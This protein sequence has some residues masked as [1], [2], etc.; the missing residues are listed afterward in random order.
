MGRE[1][2]T[3]VDGL[4]NHL[5][6]LQYREK[7]NMN[8]RLFR[9]SYRL[10]AVGLLGLSLTVLVLSLISGAAR[11]AVR[12]SPARADIVVTTTIQAAIDA[13]E[14]GDTVIIPSGIYTESLT[15]SKAVS[16]TGVSSTTTII[17]AVAGQRVLSITS[18]AID[19]SVVISG[20]KLAGGNA[21]GAYPGDRGGGVYISNGAR[22]L[23]KNTVI[24]NNHAA[25][26]GGGAFVAVGSGLTLVNVDMLSNT[27][28]Y[29]GGGIWNGGTLTVSGSTFISNSLLSLFGAE[30][31]GIFSYKTLTITNSVISGNRATFGGGIFSEDTL[32]VVNSTLAGNSASS[33]GGG[34]YSEGGATVISNTILVSNTGGSGAGIYISEGTVQVNNSE[35]FAN[36]GEIGGGIYNYRGTLTVDHT[37][38]RDNTAEGHMGNSS[39]GGGI[40]TLSD[41]QVVIVDSTFEGNSAE[42][43]GGSIYNHGIATAT[44]LICF[45]NTAFYGAC[46]YNGDSLEIED[47]TIYSNTATSA[48][49]GIYNRSSMTISSSTLSGNIISG[50]CSGAQIDNYET[51]V[52][53]ISSCTISNS[54]EAGVYNSGSVL[55]SDSTISKSR[56]GGI[57][58]NGTAIINNSILSDNNTTTYGGGID[59]LGSLVITGSILTGNSAGLSGGGI[60][61]W[62]ALTMTNSILSGNDARYGGGFCNYEGTARLDNVAIVNNTA[63]EDDGGGIYHQDASTMI[64]N[65]TLSGNYADYGGGVYF[66]A[67][68]AHL[69]NVTVMN[70][71]ARSFG[72]GISAQVVTVTLKNSIL[73]GN[74][75]GFDGPDCS[76]TVTSEAYNLIQNTEL[77]TIVGDTSGNLTGVNP[78]LGPLEDNGGSTFTHAPLA[79]SAVIDGGDPAGCVDHLG[80]PITSDQRGSPRPVDGDANG[81]AVCDIGAYEVLPVRFAGGMFSADEGTDTATITVT[82]AVSSPETVT[83]TYDTSDGTAL[84][85]SDYITASGVLAFAPSVITQT[86]IVSIIDDVLEEG[87]ETVALTL[88]SA[89]NAIIGGVNPAT[90]TILDDDFHAPD[91]YFIYLPVVIRTGP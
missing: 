59:N 5:Q 47:S 37:D 67:G 36:Q 33:A 83:V 68:A 7:T 20:L 24:A 41:N 35:V 11:A 88:S 13:A 43:Y 18:G 32:A 27:A 50:L 19:A 51:G 89:N 80:H 77:C 34:V 1:Y 82:L 73:A 91:D 62:G 25:G 49:S 14:P 61:N 63:T 12:P 42:Q 52:L 66:K 28:E 4:V 3:L 38:F 79:D 44:G 6:N 30:G 84:A 29:D 8:T 58:N 72:G 55:I 46:I 85:G 81:S 65:S 75:A 90:L 70:N 60:N 54:D 17:H 76:G 15:L 22:P 57:R 31:G 64:N 86:F 78:N 53:T 9:K 74:H 16:L 10:L 56:Y 48:G 39:F 71:T 45:D 40:Y 23:I 21:I 26:L 2:F 87:N 69:G